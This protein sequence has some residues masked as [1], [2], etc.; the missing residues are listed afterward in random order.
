M[1]PGARR[2]GFSTDADPPARDRVRPRCDRGDHHGEPRAPRLVR[3]Q[4]VEDGCGWDEIH[5]L[6]LDHLLES[7]GPRVRVL[8]FDDAVLGGAGGGETPATRRLRRPT[9]SICSSCSSSAGSSRPSTCSA[10]RE[11]ADPA[12]R[13]FGSE[14][15]RAGVERLELDFDGAD[16]RTRGREPGILFAAGLGPPLPLRVGDPEESQCH[17]VKRIWRC[18]AP[19]GYRRTAPTPAVSRRARTDRAPSAREW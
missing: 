17:L 4:L 15:L 8:D 19:R 5:R 14:C 3:A 10:G 2:R 16:R 12:G 9:T 6:W 7:D 13:L 18:D 11:P 1:T